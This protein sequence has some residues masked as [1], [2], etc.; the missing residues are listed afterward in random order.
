[1]EV[2]PKQEHTGENGKMKGFQSHSTVY[3]STVLRHD[4]CGSSLKEQ[5]CIHGF[6][7]VTW[8]KVIRW[9]ILL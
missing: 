6:Y 8:G 5:K 1:M 3:I 7:S 2:I 4:A 9:E